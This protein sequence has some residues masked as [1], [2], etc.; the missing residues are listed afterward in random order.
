MFGL[1]FVPDGPAKLTQLDLLPQ[2]AKTPEQVEK[3]RSRGASLGKL[4][5]C[6]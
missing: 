2:A 1:V 5:A 4:R 6:R 3:I